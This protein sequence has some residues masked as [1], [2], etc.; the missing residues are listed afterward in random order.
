MNT[1]LKRF[2]HKF[3][4]VQQIPRLRRLG[5]I[6]GIGLVLVS[7]VFL[8]LVLFQGWS[9]IQHQLKEAQPL[10]I[11]AAQICTFIALMLGG[12]MWYFVQK[13]VGLDIGWSD[14]IAVHLISNITK[15]VPGMAWQYV[16]KA[17][18][19]QKQGVSSRQS[20][21]TLF[22]EFVVLIDGGLLVA[23]GAIWYLGLTSIGDYILPNYTP[24]ITVIVGII[25]LFLWYQVLLVMFDKPPFVPSLHHYIAALFIGMIGWVIFSLSVWFLANSIYSVSFMGIYHT[26]FALVF[27]GIISVLII[28]VPGG[29][30]IREASLA[31][32]LTGVLPFTIGVIVGIMLR[33]TLILSEVIGLFLAFRMIKSDSSQLKGAYSIW[34]S[35]LNTPDE[36]LNIS[37]K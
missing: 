4:S 12:V 2:L 5:R 9:E 17:Y 15:Y 34:G 26:I 37:E 27:A 14:S 28:F 1:L 10:P 25:T 21:F 29:F 31:L 6:A 36:V 13:S 30:G 8:S 11:V 33:I 22:T 3:K 18:L 35:R 7:L 24:S 20:L 16:S 23:G 32:L 19:S